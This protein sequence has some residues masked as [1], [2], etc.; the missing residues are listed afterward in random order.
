MQDKLGVGTPSSDDDTPLPRLKAP[1]QYGGDSVVPSIPE[2][3]AVPGMDN[4]DDKLP[5]VKVPSMKNKLKDVPVIGGGGDASAQSVTTQGTIK[6]QD[7]VN[8]DSDRLSLDVSNL[9]RKVRFEP[10]APRAHSRPRLGAA[11]G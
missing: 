6:A 7:M 5:S 10:A 11:W 9:P 4:L 2:T 8:V 3:P 1:D